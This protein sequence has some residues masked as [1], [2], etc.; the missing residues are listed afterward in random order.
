M[1]PEPN[2][3]SGWIENSARVWKVEHRA[4]ADLCENALREC[5]LAFGGDSFVFF[6]DTFDAVAWI[7]GVLV[8]GWN[9]MSNLV[10]TEDRRS[11][12]MRLQLDYLADIEPVRHLKSPWF[13][14]SFGYTAL[15]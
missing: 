3:T 4:V 7:I 8:R 11:K 12:R 9:Q 15:P 1:P 14:L 13:I 2:G 10:G 5:E 6:D